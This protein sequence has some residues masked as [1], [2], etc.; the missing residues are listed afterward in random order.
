M[1]QGEVLLDVDF[2]KESGPLPRTFKGWALKCNWSPEGYDCFCDA[3][4]DGHGYFDKTSA[5]LSLGD[6]YELETLLEFRGPKSN[7]GAFVAFGVG[8]GDGGE[9]LAASALYLRNGEPLG[10]ANGTDGKAW[11]DFVSG[12]PLPQ[13]TAGRNTVLVRVTG[14]RARVFINGVQAGLFDA[15]WPLSG[16]VHLGS[17]AQQSFRLLRFT[18]RD[19]K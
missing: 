1:G 11:R 14:K 7:T 8:P 6:N 17:G 2:R 15:P 9:R 13:V 12:H 3:P 19:L 10:H 4:D 18:A 16:S 5:L